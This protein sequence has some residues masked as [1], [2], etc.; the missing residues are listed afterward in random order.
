MQTATDPYRKYRLAGRGLEE[1]ALDNDAIEQRVE[2][3]WYSADLPRKMRFAGTTI[4][5]LKDGKIVEKL[6]LNDGVIALT[7]LGLLIAAPNRD[8]Q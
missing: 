7:Q 8:L 4:L 2:R 6:G 1:M 5:R 3:K